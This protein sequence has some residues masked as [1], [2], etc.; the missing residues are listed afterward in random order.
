MGVDNEYSERRAKLVRRGGSSSIGK[1]GPKVSGDFE[2]Y[3]P[4]RARL[5][6]LVPSG[7][8]S[9]VIQASEDLLLTSTPSQI[10]CLRP[11][12]LPIWPSEDAATSCFDTL[13][14]MS[15]RMAFLFPDLYA[16][17]KEYGS[18]LL[19]MFTDNLLR[20]I[21]TD[22]GGDT[23]STWFHTDVEDLREFR[24]RIY[25][26]FA[27][28]QLGGGPR[29]SSQSSLESIER[30]VI[31]QTLVEQVLSYLVQCNSCGKEFEVDHSARTRGMNVVLRHDSSFAEPVG[32]QEIIDGWVSRVP[33]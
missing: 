26:D 14:L 12:E 20:L 16:Q 27:N 2:R 28:W 7:Y 5:T 10:T 11:D 22:P 17:G 8:E 32:L 4:P 31:P 33:G 6:Y 29:T 9:G 30:Q 18:Q 21:Q 25:R 19:D 13:L 15:A 24:D 1:C 3:S 23:G